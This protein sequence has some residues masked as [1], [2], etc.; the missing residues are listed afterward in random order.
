MPSQEK[1]IIVARILCRTLQEHEID[2]AYIYMHDGVGSVTIDG[3][4][5]LY[6][7]VEAAL[8]EAGL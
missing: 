4:F 6:K 2:G 1:V 7:A 3:Q 8:E 5:N